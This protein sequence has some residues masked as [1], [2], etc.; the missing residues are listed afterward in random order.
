MVRRA[1]YTGTT[2]RL[3]NGIVEEDFLPY[4]FKDSFEKDRD[5]FSVVY[6]S[7]PSRGLV[8]L[9]RMWPAV[10]GTVPQARL[11]IYYDWSMLEM[12]QPE[13]Y[14]EVASLYESVKHLDVKHHG[15]VGH[16]QL[17]A[18]LRRA[19]VW[20]YSHFES[21]EVETFCISAVKALAAG[22]TVLTVPNGALL[23]VTAGDATMV[24]NVED[25]QKAL[26]GFLQKP[27]P[28]QIRREK[29]WRAVARYGWKSVAERF[30]AL[31][32]IKDKIKDAEALD[33]AP[34]EP[35]VT[36]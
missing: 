17:H 25:Y 18:A 27:E 3:S 31:W 14:D 20:A 10:K 7:C 30:S 5:P 22:A 9:L 21:P 32:S 16:A 23:E 24:T 8:Q 13:K 11:D 15:G 6:S 29:A 28:A 34:T 19:N 2:H 35:K 1:G 4:T 36:A 26:I 33:D 12:M